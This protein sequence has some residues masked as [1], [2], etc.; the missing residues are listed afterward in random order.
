MFLETLFC[1]GFFL[2][3]LLGMFALVIYGAFKASAALV[4]TAKAEEVPVKK[5][6]AKISAEPFFIEHETKKKPLAQ[7]KKQVQPKKQV[8]AFQNPAIAAYQL[9][10]VKEHR[11]FVRKIFKKGAHP[12]AGP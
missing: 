1:V 5:A 11:G 10:E 2:T 12:R 8:V 6:E 7:L 3:P 4:L 9:L